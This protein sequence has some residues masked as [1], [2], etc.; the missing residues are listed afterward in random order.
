VDNNH[1]QRSFLSLQRFYSLARVE[2]SRVK[3][4][5]RYF[6]KLLFIYLIKFLIL[7]KYSYILY[8]MQ[9]TSSRITTSPKVLKFTYTCPAFNFKTKRYECHGKEQ[10]TSEILVDRKTMIMMM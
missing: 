1:N 7:W 10:L 9:I 4:M 8:S 6:I 3:Y 5:E 2:G